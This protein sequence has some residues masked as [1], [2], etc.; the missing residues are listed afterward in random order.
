MDNDMKI[1]NKDK[2]ITEYINFNWESYV[3]NYSDLKYIKTKDEAW[4]HWINH[5]K[6][7]DR[8]FLADNCID[9]DIFDWRYY[10]EINLDLKYIKTKDEAWEHWINYGKNEDRPYKKKV[11]RQLFEF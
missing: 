8:F 2:D 11:K 3:N 5:G 7:E 9:F 10:I 6:N 1:Q 4:E